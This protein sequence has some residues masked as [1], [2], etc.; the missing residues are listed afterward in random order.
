LHILQD[1]ALNRAV[2]VRLSVEVLS[3]VTHSVSRVA[4]NGHLDALWAAG[5][6]RAVAL[7]GNDSGC[8]EGQA[9]SVVFDGLLEAVGDSLNL[10]SCRIVRVQ[11][12]YAR[13]QGV[14]VKEGVFAMVDANCVRL[15]VRFET[16]IT[17]GGNLL[18]DVGLGDVETLEPDKEG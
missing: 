11:L 8:R 1:L 5:S 2:S 6:G 9:H 14:H 4:S 13:A 18:I 15:V 17:H 7:V 16:L 3:A 12:I 10:C